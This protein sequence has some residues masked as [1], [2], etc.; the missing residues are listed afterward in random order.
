MCSLNN[1]YNG[2]YKLISSIE[3]TLALRNYHFYYFFY[4]E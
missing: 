3:Y 2:K 1:K 4:L